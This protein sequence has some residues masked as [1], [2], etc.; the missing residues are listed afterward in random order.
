[1]RKQSARASAAERERDDA[2]ATV[3]GLRAKLSE[4]ASERQTAVA[5]R[6]RQGMELSKLRKLEASRNAEIEAPPRAAAHTD[7][8]ARRWQL[9]RRPA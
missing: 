1:M 8:S 6:E 2:L 5:M 4:A 3:A 9:T 7:A